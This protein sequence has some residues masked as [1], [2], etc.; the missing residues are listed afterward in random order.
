MPGRAFEHAPKLTSPGRAGRR[1]VILCSSRFISCPNFKNALNSQGFPRWIKIRKGYGLVFAAA[2]LWGTTGTAQ[3]LAPQGAQPQVVGAARLAIGGLILMSIAVSRGALRSN[4]K[5]PFAVTATAA[6]SMAFYQLF[7]FSAVSRTGVAVGTI[8]AIG[9][10]P[11][12]AGVLGYLLRGERPGRRWALATLLAVA[13]CGL[14]LLP[15]Q[16]VTIDLV[17]IIL[18][19]GAGLSY[20]A[21]TVLSK[22]LLETHHPDAVIAV[23]FCLAAL[24]LSPVWFRTRLEWLLQPRGLLVV[25]HLG[26]IATA[27]A[28]ALFA[29][30]LALTPVAAAVT[31]SLAEPLTAGML[32]LTLLGEQLSLLMA[33]GMGCIL[34]GLLLVSLGGRGEQG[35]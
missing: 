24:I 16:R 4:R 3:A 2:V 22:R 30:G 34:S 26:V 11:I 33:L 27:A 5:W 32:G 15:G 8:I 31:I 10:A 13:G 20:A 17:G 21:Y 28:Y 6:M 18:A 25:L 12:L 7:F 29:R 14:L 1:W 19:L 23:V 9:S 35:A